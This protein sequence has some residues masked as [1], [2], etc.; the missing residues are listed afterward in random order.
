MVSHTMGRNTMTTDNDS[1]LSRRTIL[2]TGAA[3]GSLMAVP[4]TAAASQSQHTDV[5]GVP[6]PGEVTLTFINNTDYRYVFDHRVDDESPSGTFSFSDDTI[7]DG[8]CAG[9]KWGP[10]YNLTSVSADSKKVTVEATHKVEAQAVLGPEQNYYTCWK[11]F[12]PEQPETKNDC[13]RGSWADYHF[14]NQG[15]C[16]RYVNTGE[17]SR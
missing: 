7:S 16:I 14:R 3:I 9:R 4:A 17:D 10:Y 6:G 8:P 11:T 1:V 2:R 15:Q 5:Q 13:K 12:Y